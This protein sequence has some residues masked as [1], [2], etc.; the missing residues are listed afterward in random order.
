MHYIRIFYFVSET[1]AQWRKKNK[2]KI[3]NLQCI[4]DSINSDEMNV[5]KN[6]E[7]KNHKYYM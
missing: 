7:N 4:W 5:W 6:N 2:K 1:M 3:G